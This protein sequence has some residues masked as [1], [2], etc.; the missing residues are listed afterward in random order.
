MSTELAV[1]VGSTIGTV[2]IGVGL[3]ITWRK[4]GSQQKTRD[5]DIAKKQAVRNESIDNSLR[6]LKSNV[7]ENLRQTAN[8]DGKVGIINQNCA[9]RVADFNARI[10]NN[11]RRL[12]DIEVDKS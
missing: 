1:A 10:K 5:L 8:L 2:I 11:E 6:E 9:G 3:I 7:G 12:H 4:N